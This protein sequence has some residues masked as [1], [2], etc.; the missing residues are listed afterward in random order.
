MKRLFLV[1]HHFV[2]AAVAWTVAGQALAAADGNVADPA[3][4]TAIRA[5]GQRP[6]WADSAIRRWAQ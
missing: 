2:L 3:A 4:L 1:C 5:P 6:W